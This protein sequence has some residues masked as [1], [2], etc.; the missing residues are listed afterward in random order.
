VKRFF[1]VFFILA[2]A[3][4]HKPPAQPT[5]RQPAFT[6]AADSIIQ[7]SELN[8]AH[9]GIEVFDPERNQLLYS[10]DGNRHH[11]PASNTKLVVTTVALGVLGPDW[12]Y[13]TDIRAGGGSANNPTRLL[14]IAR[15][16]PT[17]SARFNRDDFAVLENLADSLR[18][19]G[20]QGA[21]SLIID[22]SYLGPERVNGTWEV[23]DLP[24]TSA[25]PI[26]SLAI[27]E[28][29]IRV[30]VTPGA[31]V[32]APA[33]AAVLGVDHVFPMRVSVT[34]DTAKA[35]PNL[36]ASYEAWPDTIVLT[37]RVPLGRP[38]TSSLAA[39]DANQFAAMALASVLGR[40][41]IATSPPRIVFDTIEAAALRTQT[42][43]VVA[44]WTSPP[45][46][47]IVAGILRPSQNW[48][49]EQVV[50]TLG[51]DKRGRGSWSAGIDVERR[52]LIDVAK[53][54][55]MSFFLRDASGLSAQNLLSPRAITQILEHVRNQPWG[56]TYRQS[57]PMPG[58]AKSTLSNR[59]QGYEGKIFAKTGT[60]TNVAS[61]SGYA[62]T[63]SGKQLIFS[64][65]VNSS[66]R[67]SAAVRRGI[68]RL[69][70]LLLDQTD[71]E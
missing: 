51:A 10:H 47:E 45:M 50:R 34:T 15:G 21:D 37:G 9:W 5:P 14:V 55:S 20:I 36:D 24:G 4:A 59:L 32:G 54:D 19:A 43:R 56:E 29:E 48:I 39:P 71:W 52:Y 33:T 40:R 1:P 61:L 67:P 42:E 25:P 70:A 26:G 62:A 8:Q 49:A 57:L 64:I 22:A 66:G 31:T 3:C 63:R 44:S 35:R 69:A 6:V 65:M 60:I 58:L 18:A 23:A 7:V 28:G 11:I 46:S 12:R 27:A 38:D 53:L 16:D 30:V 68:D 41:G 13:R 2:A 17:W